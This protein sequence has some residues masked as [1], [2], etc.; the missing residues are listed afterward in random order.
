MQA[1][2][3]GVL[4]LFWGISGLSIVYLYVLLYSGLCRDL[5]YMKEVRTSP[6]SSMMLRLQHA[7]CHEAAL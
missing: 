3:H 6:I 7:S 2:E 4:D 5:I 1:C